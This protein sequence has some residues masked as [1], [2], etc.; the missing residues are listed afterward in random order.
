MA[1]YQIGIRVTT[2]NRSNV[3]T[4]NVEAQSKEEAVDAAM[5]KVG[6]KPAAANCDKMEVATVHKR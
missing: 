3:I 5:E 2:G 4:V 1:T 6:A